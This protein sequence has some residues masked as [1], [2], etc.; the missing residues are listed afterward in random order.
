MATLD[1]VI[2]VLI[3]GFGVRGFMAGFVREILSLCAVVAGILAVRVFH[4]P[5]TAFLAPHIGSEYPAALLAFIFLFGVIYMSV[6]LVANTLSN[7]ARNVGLGT[8]DR[9]LGFGFGAVKG[10]L[11]ATVGFALFTMVYDALYGELSPRPDWLRYTQSYPL[12]NAG[13]EAMSKW[14]AENRSE[15]GLIGFGEAMVAPDDPDSSP[16]RGGR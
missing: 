5:V 11:I 7:Q 6:K 8:M 12:L 4:E 1:I 13:A 2:F 15:G 3:G 16:H 9:V 10:M 14:V